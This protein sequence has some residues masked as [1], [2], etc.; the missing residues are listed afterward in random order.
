[1]SQDEID[2]RHK[3]PRVTNHADTFVREAASRP[4]ETKDFAVMGSGMVPLAL[5]VGF[6]V[7]LLVWGLLRLS[8]FLTE[9]MWH[10]A[11]EA[12]GWVFFPV[13]ACTLGGLLIGLWSKAFDSNPK[14]LHHV[15]SQ[16][17][18]EGGYHV[19]NMP[20]NAVAFLLPLMFGGSVGPEAGLAGIIAA[21][22]TWI[23]ST[24]KRAGVRAAQAV[25]SAIPAVLSVVF[26][27]PFAGILLPLDGEEESGA[28]KLTRQAK[29]VLYGASAFGALAA[30]AV[31]SLLLGQSEGLPRFGQMAVTKELLPWMVPLLAA[32]Y[33]L[34]LIALSSEHFSAKASKAMGDRKILKPVLCGLVLGCIAVALPNVLFSGEHQTAE[35]MTEWTTVSAAV[36]VLTGLVKAVATPFCISMGWCGGAFFPYIF[37]GVT[38]GYGVAA[39]AGLDPVFCAAVVT[40]AMLG[41]TLGKPVAAIALL[42]LCFPVQGVVWMGLAA[43]VGSMLPAPKWN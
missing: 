21:G 39:F 4:L 12:C 37:S 40:A 24:L 41:R 1:M 34:A 11:A 32:G 38:V 17:K 7:G 25:D 19:K 29:L 20:A 26:A 31:L 6:A 36:L 23:S 8:G 2:P 33:V 10:R 27:S 28:Y 3:E 5:G 18:T 9:L 35:I 43:V 42:A 30:A 16:V 15:M 22:C 13:V 14:S